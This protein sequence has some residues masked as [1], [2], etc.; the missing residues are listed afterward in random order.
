LVTLTSLVDQENKLLN[1]VDCICLTLV[2][3]EEET[4]GKSPISHF[5]SPQ[6]LLQVQHTDIKMNVYLLFNA[7]ADWANGG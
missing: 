4:V 5:K 3:T 6:D 7:C 1:T 2:N